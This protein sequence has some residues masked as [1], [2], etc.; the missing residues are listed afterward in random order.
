MRA[1][2]RKNRIT[3]ESKQ[4]TRNELGE[5]VVAWAP[6]ANGTVWAKAKPIRGAEF[7]AAAQLQAEQIVTF[8]INFRPDVAETMRIIWNG[9]HY[10][11]TSV[12]SVNGANIDL[13]LMGRKGVRDGR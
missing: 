6:L 7:F 2:Q 1:G 10:D 13:E 12:I 3:I 9:D 5:E 11:I 8:T 4:V